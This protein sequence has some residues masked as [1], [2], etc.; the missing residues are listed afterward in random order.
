MKLATFVR[1]SI[2]LL[3]FEQSQAYDGKPHP[4]DPMKPHWAVVVGCGKCVAKNNPDLGDYIKCLLYDQD[5]PRNIVT[6]DSPD[7]SGYFNTITLKPGN[8]PLARDICQQVN[9]VWYGNQ[10]TSIVLKCGTCAFESPDKWTAFRNNIHNYVLTDKVDASGVF[11]SIT[12]KDNMCPQIPS[13][14]TASSGKWYGS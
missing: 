9:N 10:H 1:I 8:C 14:C 13:A 12:L 4:A 2:A 11:D 7:N 3:A 5:T 6:A